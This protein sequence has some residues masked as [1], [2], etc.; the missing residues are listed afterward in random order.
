MIRETYKMI[1][2]N[3]IMIQYIGEQYVL[4][5][6]EYITTPNDRRLNYNKY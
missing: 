4:F 6:P 5:I 3:K 2:N 1:R